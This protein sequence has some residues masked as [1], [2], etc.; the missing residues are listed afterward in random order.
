MTFGRFGDRLP[1]SEIDKMSDINFEL[2][3]A[4]NYL[5]HYKNNIRESFTSSASNI[6]RLLRFY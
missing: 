5:V 2:T 3:L 4:L 6:V 1:S